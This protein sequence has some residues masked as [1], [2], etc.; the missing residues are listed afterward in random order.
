[1]ANRTSSLAASSVTGL[2]V[3]SALRADLGE[4][5]LDNDRVLI[6]ETS[7][8]NVA[9][10]SRPKSYFS[11]PL[12]RTADLTC[13]Q[14]EPKFR[15]ESRTQHNPLSYQSL[16]SRGSCVPLNASP[17]GTK[18]KGGSARPRRGFLLGLPPELA[19]CRRYRTFS[20]SPKNAFGHPQVSPSPHRRRH[21]WS[22]L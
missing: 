9:L 11:E 10:A 18:C 7:L 12:A 8:A 16:V 17:S 3:Q 21:G 2:G 15:G 4:V 20:C 19:K 14:H 1:M 5:C 13:L 22:V 6:D